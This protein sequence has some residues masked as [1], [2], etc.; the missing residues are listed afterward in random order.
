M[1]YFNSIK[2]TGWRQ[3]SEVEIDLSRPVTVLTGQNGCG[4]T[5][6]LNIL[7][8]HFGWNLSF[9]STP[10][11]G[12]RKTQQFWSDVAHRRFEEFEESA[13]E[14]SQVGEIVYDDGA[15]CTLQTTKVVSPQYQLTQVGQQPVVGLHIPSHRP[16]A[17]YH[18]VG[19][20]PTNPTTA[21]QQYQNFQQLLA[22][23]YG[24]GTNNIRNPGGIQ[25]QSIISLALFGYGNQAVQAN[26]EFRRIFEE[27]Q[28]IL[29][30]VLPKELGFRR[31][32]VRMPEV[33]LV[34]DSGE[35]SLDAMSGGIN[36]LFGIA[37]QI[38]MYGATADKCTVTIDEPENHLHPSM[39]RSL[40][41]SLAEAFPRYRF[42]IA[43]H[44]P[45][46]VSSF[47]LASV[48]GLIFGD[49]NRV[50]SHRL[51]LADLAG[52][53]NRV[54][55]EILDVPSNLP[56]W[57]EKE[58]E[59]V[60]GQHGEEDIKVRAR[61]IMTKLKELGLTEALAEFRSGSEDEKVK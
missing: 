14:A 49:D 7:S 25:K 6:I 53:P 31:L 42:I 36:A 9:V 26:P 45:F 35:F 58:I 38:H 41:P 57:V 12:K 56:I 13:N 23:T 43:T 18:A 28:G 48:Y 29:M 22:Q 33:V 39:Q 30:K 32:E 50:T 54:L 1:H 5:T 21:Q 46:I 27:F 4:K 59:S 20:I 44:S 15:R 16:P 60:M 19:Q 55:R 52:T 11:W 10:F 34:T 2:L 24:P 47:P 61:M 37:W 3:F 40:L 51:E 17:V 8:R